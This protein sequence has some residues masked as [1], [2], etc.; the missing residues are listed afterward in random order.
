MH[1]CTGWSEVLLGTCC[2]V[3]FLMLWPITYLIHNIRKCIC[4][5]MPVY[6]CVPWENSDLPLLLHSLIRIFT[7]GFLIADGA[8]ISSCRLWRLWLDYWDAQADFSL[9]WAHISNGKFLMIRLV[10]VNILRKSIS[11]CHRPVRVAD[12]PMTA[13]CRFT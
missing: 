1:G 8:K 13:R 4:E 5:H 12:G 11:G 6:A 7:G 9:H 10:P 2:K 3:H